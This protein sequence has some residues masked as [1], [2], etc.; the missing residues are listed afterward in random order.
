M[1]FSSSVFLLYFLPALLLCYFL[2]P[3]RFLPARNLVLLVFSLIFY[4]FGGLR[5][6]GLLAACILVNWLGGRL[7]GQGGTA[8][9]RRALLI[10]VIAAN[11]A[12]LGWFK[13]AGF[14]ARTLNALGLSVPVPDIVL[15][16]GISFFTF[17]GMSYVIDVYRGKARVQRDPLKVALYIALFPQL[18]AGPIVRYTG[19]EA[20]LSRRS[21]TLQG[22]A[23]GLTRFLYGFGKKMILANAMGEIADKTFSLSQGGTLSVTL[24]WLGALAYTFQIYFDFS[25]Y[26]D[27]AIGLGKLFG[28][29]FPENFNYPYISASVTEFWRRWHMSLSSWFR[30][31]VYIPLGGNRCSRRRHILNLLAVW[32][33]T[34]LWH[35][36]NWTFV[37]WGLYYGLLLIA[38]KYLLAD[39]LPRIPVPLR[40]LL[41]FVIVLLGWVLFRSDT[42]ADAGAYLRVMFGGGAFATGQTVYFLRQYL[43]ELLLCVLAC[44]PVK[45]IPMNLMREKAGT[46]RVWFLALQAAPKALALLVFALGYMKLVFG[47]FNPFIYFQF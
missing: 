19:V 16:I 42:I 36:A 21:S 13:Y 33:L 31:Y 25:G 37:A 30:D 17:Q 29:R 41:T 15:P 47:S 23:D 9:R 34:G 18:V 27:M 6:L 1:L 32:G 22:F 46:S 44:F 40:R 35:G 26:S 45:Y 39:L 28:F 5:Y 24:A 4:G 43:P 7:L 2:V 10:L 20:A 12:L 38:E 11:L 8:R 3:R 14:A